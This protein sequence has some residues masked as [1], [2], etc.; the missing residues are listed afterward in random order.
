SPL[1]TRGLL[2]GL[3]L[4]GKV[5]AQHAR[6]DAAV[7]MPPPAPMVVRAPT[8]T[9]AAETAAPG[10]PGAPAA[11]PEPA[12]TAPAPAAAPL[13][14]DFVQRVTEQVV[15]S[16]DARALAARERFGSF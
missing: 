2:A 9:T 6:S 11:R 3:V 15:R 10:A 16:L 5:G 7:A 13:P 8:A 1:V 14:P 4:V 12:E